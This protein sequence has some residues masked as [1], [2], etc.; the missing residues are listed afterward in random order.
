MDFLGNQPFRPGPSFR[1]KLEQ[2][3]QHAQ[4][5]PLD[6]ICESLGEDVRRH[7]ARGNIYEHHVVFATYFM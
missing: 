6:L 7:K 1:P 5:D 4:M 2:T 3:S